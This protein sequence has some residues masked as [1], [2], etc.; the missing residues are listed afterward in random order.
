MKRVIT[1]TH[2]LLK[3]EWPVMDVVPDLTAAIT[4]RKRKGLMNV[5]NIAPMRSIGV[6]QKWDRKW[7]KKALTNGLQ[8]IKYYFCTVNLYFFL[9]QSI[10]NLSAKLW[11]SKKGGSWYKSGSSK[12]LLFPNCSNGC[13]HQYVNWFLKKK[14]RFNLFI[15]HEENAYYWNP[16]CRFLWAWFTA[17]ALE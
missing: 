15:L 13:V 10:T 8:M 3:I 1:T 2:T 16:V 7:T 17:I 4:V 5:N 6:N 12:G 14:I 11:A 9:F